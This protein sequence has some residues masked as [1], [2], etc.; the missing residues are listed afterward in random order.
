MQCSQQGTPLGKLTNDL[1]LIARQLHSRRLGLNPPLPHNTTTTTNNNLP[2]SST[3]RIPLPS[4]PPRRRTRSLPLPL[5]IP[6]PNR[7]TPPTRHPAPLPLELVIQPQMRPGFFEQ[8]HAVGVAHALGQ[9]QRRVVGPVAGVDAG[10]ALEQVAQDEGFWADGCE[11]CVCVF[12]CISS[13]FTP[14]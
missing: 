5:P 10:A 2:P 1:A 4:L 12:G 3:P 9:V 14:G 7:R 11:V 6:A 8:L 13:T